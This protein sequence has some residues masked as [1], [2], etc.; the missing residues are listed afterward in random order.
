MRLQGKVAIVTGAGKGIGQATALLFAREGARVVVANRGEQAGRQTV[1]V[2]RDAG[3]EAVFVK[4]DVSDPE[5]AN[6]LMSETRRAFGRLDILVNNAGIYYQGDVETTPVEQWGQILAVNLSGA[7]YCC[8]AAIPLMREGG[9]GVIVNVASEA[10]L[11]VIPGQVAY[12]VS[13]AGLIMLTRCMAVDHARDNIRVN[14]ICPGT[15][16]TP[17]VEQA[18][19]RQPD[20]QAARRALESSRPL[21][22]LGRP[23]EIAEGILYL[24]SDAS[25]YCTGA[26]LTIDGGRTAL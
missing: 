12:N 21:N 7:F 5:Q 18:L 2:I 6:Y 15:T 9:G 1:G 13:K 4:V 24:A 25:P 10:G 3:G 26:V 14:C 17:L 11:V 23:E 22:R 8:K 20:P 19:S 16:Y